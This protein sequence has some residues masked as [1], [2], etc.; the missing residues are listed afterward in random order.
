MKRSSGGYRS[1]PYVKPPEKLQDLPR[2]TLRSLHKWI[3]LSAS[4]DVGVLAALVRELQAQAEGV[5]SVPLATLPIVK[6]TPYLIALYEE[7]IR[8]AF[9][10]LGLPIPEGQVANL[11]SI[12]DPNV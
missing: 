9:E 12:D 8:D 2:E 10:Y 4:A 1:S 11:Y 7:D 6:S 3:G 5:V